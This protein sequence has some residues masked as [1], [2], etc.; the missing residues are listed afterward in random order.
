[1]KTPRILGADIE[2]LRCAVAQLNHVG[3]EILS[4]EIRAHAVP[5]IHIVAHPE[6]TQLD[7][8][9]VHC[10]FDGITHYAIPYASCTVFWIDPAPVPGALPTVFPPLNAA[11]ERTAHHG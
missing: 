9:Y 7:G 6:I 1:M 3:V 8:R 4:A 10:L 2:V 5:M 11:T